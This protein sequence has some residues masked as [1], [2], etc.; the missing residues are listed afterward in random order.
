M[1]GQERVS[2][3]DDCIS[4]VKEAEVLTGSAG[5]VF[6]SPAV[7]GAIVVFWDGSA[8]TVVS[9]DPELAGVFTEKK[10]AASRLAEIARSAGLFSQCI[11][12]LLQLP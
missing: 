5:R 1:L 4:L 11:G 8:L 12:K 2:T 3:I 9:D 7:A 10:I 6:Q